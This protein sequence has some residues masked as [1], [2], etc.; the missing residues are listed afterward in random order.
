MMYYAGM[1][2]TVDI[3]KGILDDLVGIM[4]ETKKSPAIAR[5]VTEFVKRTKAKEFGKKLM[6]GYFD[7]PSTNEETESLDR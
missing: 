4:G 6:E 7:Y 3:D 5:A 1:R 2:V